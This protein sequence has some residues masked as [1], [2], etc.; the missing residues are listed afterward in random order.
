L[1]TIGEV[2]PLPPPKVGLEAEIDADQAGFRKNLRFESR[3]GLQ[4]PSAAGKLPK[5]ATIGAW[6]I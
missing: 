4:I 2:S 6:T 1:E 5:Q 3:M